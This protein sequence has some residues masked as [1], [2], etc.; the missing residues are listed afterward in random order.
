[1]ASLR[2][3]A[4]TPRR[5][6]VEAA[7]LVGLYRL[8]SARGISLPAKSA[9]QQPAPHRS[10]D[11]CGNP[12]SR[13]P[14]RLAQRRLGV[15]VDSLAVPAQDPFR[16]DLPELPS[17]R[18]QAQQWVHSQPLLP[19]VVIARGA[20]RVSGYEDALLG[21]PQ[22]N[23]LPEAAV[24]DGDELERPDRLAGDDIVRHPEACRQLRAGAV[25]T[26]EQLDHSRGNADRADP[27]L[28][29][30]PVDRID[31]P[32]VPA[33]DERMRAALE[34]LVDD[35]AEAAVELVAPADS[36]SGE[37]TGTPYGASASATTGS[38]R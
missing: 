38:A 19:R 11:L 14:E 18:T 21:P 30:V 10:G 28:H 17:R 22:G 37:S 4:S 3:I 8:Q 35:P 15:R 27:I 13:C 6:A 5:G 25:V 29:T 23:F 20:E 12:P 1:M 26:V 34:E 9:P 33:C 16:R 36:H 32:D 24:A 31:Q 7:T 2:A